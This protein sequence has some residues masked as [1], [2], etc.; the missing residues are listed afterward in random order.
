[1][2]DIALRFNKDMLVLSA[3]L[4]AQLER[5]GIDV[6]DTEFVTFFE[7]DAVHD[8]L[9][10]ELLA[11]ASC[12]VTN[13]ADATPARLAH[14]SLEGRAPEFVAAALEAVQGLAPQHV[15]GEIGPCGLPLDAASKAS[16]NENRSQYARAVR[17]FADEEL[18]AFFLNGFKTCDDLK[19]ALMGVRQ[20][21]DL[22]L[23][24]SADVGAD[25]LLAGG[26]GSL[27]EAMGIM[28]EYGA[29]V[30]GIATGADVDEAEDLARRM[31]QATCLPLLVQLKVERRDPK[32]GRPTKENPYYCP[33]VMAQAAVRLRAA[34]VQFL[35]A[36]GQATPAYT[37]ALA[38]SVI[39]SDVV[40]ADAPV[41]AEGERG[42][43]ADAST[44]DVAGSLGGAS[45]ASAKAAGENVAD[46]GASGGEEP[47]SS[48]AA[49]DA[50]ERLVA[51]ARAEVAA[52]LGK[53]G[54]DD[55]EGAS[56]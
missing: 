14:F 17:S 29:S 44:C 36:C 42:A 49:D 9:R 45:A 13:T 15:L 6:D 39:G 40:L 10:L 18:D 16:L 41:S 50:L 24:A 25:G 47:A 2:P 11:G 12:L 30:A 1:M 22:P 33:D 27:E 52:A 35:R 51:T 26:R 20:A 4:H 54:Q 56:A 53:D 8:A 23:F 5:Q 46:E 3:P 31:A 55:R 37:G 32:Q 28:E 43:V 34:G 7:S 19:C 21:T 38:A 48:S